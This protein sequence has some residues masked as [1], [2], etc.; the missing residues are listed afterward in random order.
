M[1]QTKQRLSAEA[2][3]AAV[4]DTACS[5]FSRSSYRGATTAEIAREAGISEPILYRHFGSKRDLY[6]ACL[7]EAWETFREEATAAMA[8]DRAGCLGA[9]SDRYMAKGNRL[10]VVDL[11]IQA[12]TV[13]PDDPV[14]AKAL[15]Q[16][17]REVHDF[18]A[19][20]IR[21]GQRLGV[22][23]ADRD[24]EAEA[25]IFVGGGLLATM[26]SR[27]GG[28]LGDDLQRVRTERRRWIL[29]TP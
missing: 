10:R 12:L 9:I 17:I 23:H 8:E 25:W 19:D 13:A 3:R 22:V 4:L 16:Q 28:L 7:E 2:R 15:R 26:D 1:T 21:D 14:I 24:P 11:W 6:L 27:L 5:V 20:V 18:F 29:A